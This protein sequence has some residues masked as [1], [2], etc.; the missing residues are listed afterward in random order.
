MQSWLRRS[1]HVGIVVGIAAMA[2]GIVALARGVTSVL[3]G[4]LAVAAICIG[5]AGAVT[6]FT[7]LRRL[8]LSDAI[9][10]MAALASGCGAH[11]L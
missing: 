4:V 2:L 5:A 6:S 8:W 9:V 7:T 1:L 3:D 10:F 11:R